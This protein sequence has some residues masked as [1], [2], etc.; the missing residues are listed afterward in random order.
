MRRVRQWLEFA[1]SMLTICK[2]KRALARR[3]REAYGDT[4]IEELR[5]EWGSRK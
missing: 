2:V 5:A 1:R 4:L 3:R